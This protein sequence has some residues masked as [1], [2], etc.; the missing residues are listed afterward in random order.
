LGRGARG[1]AGAGRSVTLIIPGLPAGTT[2]VALN[3]TAVNP[4]ATGYLTV[5]PGGEVQ[6]GTTNLSFTRGQTISTI[7]V[8]AVGPDG[9]VTFY[10]SAG[11][12]DILADLTG[13]FT[14]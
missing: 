2:A 8:V 5:Y 11:S 1:R 9:K 3:V 6:Q 13:Y 4:T 10:N 7:V 14:T 12:V